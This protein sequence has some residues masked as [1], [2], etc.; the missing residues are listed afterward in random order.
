[1]AAA[2]DHVFQNRFRACRI[3]FPGHL[4]LG[5]TCCNAK[6]LLAR[7]VVDLDHDPIDPESERIAARSHVAIPGDG[8]VHRLAKRVRNEVK[9][10]L[11]K[12]REF[13]G[14]RRKTNRSPLT[15]F[16]DVKGEGSQEITLMTVLSPHDAAAGIARVFTAGRVHSRPVRHGKD[17]FE[18]YGSSEGRAHPGG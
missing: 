9:A 2:H 10:Q 1:M 16:I 3:K 8:I 11:G 15:L 7:H 18:T 6:R 4:S 12:A 13:V 17:H 14:F 5:S